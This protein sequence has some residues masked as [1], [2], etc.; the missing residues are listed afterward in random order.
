MRGHVSWQQTEA[1]GLWP[2]PGPRRGAFTFQSHDVMDCHLHLLSVI[3]KCR[4]SLS[5]RGMR[6]RNIPPLFS[7]PPF[8]DGRR[9]GTNK[10]K[11]THKNK[12][13]QTEKQEKAT[14]GHKCWMTRPDCTKISPLNRPVASLISSA[15]WKLGKAQQ[16]RKLNWMHP[17]GVSILYPG[18]L[19]LSLFPSLY[20]SHWRRTKTWPGLKLRNDHQAGGESVVKK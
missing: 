18:E 4:S 14:A 7:K 3:P 6:A 11:A 20:L 15:W 16:C 9:N 5:H 1:C 2:L 12:H 8:T 13:R 10:K 17:L 19:S